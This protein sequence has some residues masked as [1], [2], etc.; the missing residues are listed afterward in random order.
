MG[1]YMD[2]NREAAAMN[3]AAAAL[4]SADISQGEQSLIILQS[5]LCLLREKNLLTR[6]DIEDLCHKVEMRAAGEGGNALP[7][8]AESA[9]AASSK[10]Q[11]LTSYIGQ[12]YGGKHARSF[13]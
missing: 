2:S 5:L 13:R 6:A 10:M 1:S 8:C 4:D 3:S 9:N 11:R 12:R 7:C